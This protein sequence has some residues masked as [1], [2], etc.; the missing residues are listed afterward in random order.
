MILAKKCN[1]LTLNNDIFLTKK[2]Y[3]KRSTLYYPRKS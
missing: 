3:A 1:C 2:I